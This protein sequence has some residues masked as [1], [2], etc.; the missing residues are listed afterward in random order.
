MDTEIGE[1]GFSAHELQTG[2][3]LLQEPDVTLAPFMVPRGT[4]QT[5]IVARLFSNFRELSGVLHRHKELALSKSLEQVN[6]TRHLRQLIPGE[7]GCRRMPSKARPA[8]H[9]LGEP[10]SGPYVVMSQNTFNSAKL[11]DPATGQWVDNGNDIPL[12]QLLAGPRRGLLKFEQATDADRS[13]AQMIAGDGTD[14]LPAEVKATGWKASKTTGWR[15][16]RKGQFVA[17]RPDN[18]RR[19]AVAMVVHNDKNAVSYTHLTLPTILLV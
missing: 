14:I 1:S 6:Q 16:L 8:K 7:M 9:L 17:Y 2:D 4:A 11:K 15:G 13:V 19:L 12:E 5:D 10:S 18:S 3:S